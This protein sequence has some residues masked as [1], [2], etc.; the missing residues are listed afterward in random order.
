MGWLNP[1][2]PQ[3]GI[4]GWQ[5]MTMMKYF[6]EDEDTT[7]PYAALNDSLWAYEGVVLPGGMIIV[8]RWWHPASNGRDQDVSSVCGSCVGRLLTQIS[9][10]RAPF[11]SGTWTRAWLRKRT[12]EQV[13][14]C[15][16]SHRRRS[17]HPFVTCPAGLRHRRS[18]G[19]RQRAQAPVGPSRP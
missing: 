8:G 13:D 7:S 5:R 6:V 4:P 17:P 16:H 12:E 10:T 3:Q 2:P 1:L 11:C 19:R 18:R 9:N 14:T 15:R